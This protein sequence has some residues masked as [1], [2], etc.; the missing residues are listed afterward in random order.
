[1]AK[2]KFH[3]GKNGPGKCTAQIKCRLS[4][5]DGNPAVH[6]DTLAEAHIAYGQQLNAENNGPIAT[7]ISR[8]RNFTDEDVEE[9]RTQNKAFNDK[10]GN[11]SHVI[12]TL[13]N[14]QEKQASIKDYLADGELKR[15][16]SKYD[17][18]I[19]DFIDK[20]RAENKKLYEE[21]KEFLKRNKRL[22][23]HVCNID[24]EEDNK[25]RAEI[26]RARSNYRSYTSCGGGSARC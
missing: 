1:M 13:E 5:Q 22:E 23:T 9:F 11:N 2:E 4:G 3:I 21:H 20:A 24:V 7:P 8:K 18:D 12:E 17:Q 10:L 6:Y 15:L 25:K 16:M 14:I 26:L 19:Q